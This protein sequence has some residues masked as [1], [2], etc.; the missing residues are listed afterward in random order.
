MLYSALNKQCCQI[1]SRKGYL[2]VGGL[3]DRKQKGEINGYWCP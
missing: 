2:G 3:A 1:K